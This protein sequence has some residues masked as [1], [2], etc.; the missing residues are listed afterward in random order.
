M[1]WYKRS[2]EAIYASLATMVKH[3]PFKQDTQ[4]SNPW[5]GTE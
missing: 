2:G 3:L 4:G 1:T 5:R